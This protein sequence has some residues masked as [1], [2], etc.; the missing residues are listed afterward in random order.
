ML[1]FGQ[2][3]LNAI[4]IYHS[5]VRVIWSIYMVLYTMD[6]NLSDYIWNNNKLSIMYANIYCNNGIRCFNMNSYGLYTL[7]MFYMVFI[8]YECGVHVYTMKWWSNTMNFYILWFLIWKLVHLYMVIFTCVSQIEYNLYQL[9][10]EIWIFVTSL[11]FFW[12]YKNGVK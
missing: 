12:I 3:W 9:Y 11:L 8:Y 10:M 1:E 4:K 7:W 6:F 2:F 5:C